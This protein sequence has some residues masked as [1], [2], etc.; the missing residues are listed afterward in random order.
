MEKSTL[1]NRKKFTSIMPGVV[2][3]S[4]DASFTGP[5][6]K[7]WLF[8]GAQL[9][10]NYVPDNW[11]PIPYRPDSLTVASMLYEGKTT[12]WTVFEN[13]YGYR[14]WNTTKQALVVMSGGVYGGLVDLIRME[15]KH[16]I[17]TKNFYMTSIYMESVQ[18]VPM[19]QGRVVSANMDARSVK[20][21]V[22][23]SVHDL[24][25]QRE[26]EILNAG[27]TAY[28]MG[29]FESSMHDDFV[30]NVIDYEA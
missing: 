17:V 5:F 19:V 3:L 13:T 25:T 10:A 9:H 7:N 14:A 29:I 6:S 30:K 4:M 16:Q 1:G 20:A 28:G 23:I 18:L 11:V 8:M 2:V 27:H 22:E 24:I 26:D 15:G 21:E 12:R